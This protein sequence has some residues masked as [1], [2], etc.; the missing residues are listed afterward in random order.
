MGGNFL[1]P[2]VV[3][4]ANQDMLAMQEETFGP[5]VPIATYSDLEDAIQMA[6]DTQFGLAAYFF[7]NDYRTGSIYITHLIMVSLVGMMAV[8]QQLTHH[9]AV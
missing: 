7:T 5:I 9:L 8:H 6:N 4:N 2:V 1:K 3:S